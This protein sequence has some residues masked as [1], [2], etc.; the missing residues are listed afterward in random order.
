MDGR[1]GRP[2]TGR[3]DRQGGGKRGGLCVL[4]SLSLLRWSG[5]VRRHVPL[6]ALEVKSRL[7]IKVKVKVELT[8]YWTNTD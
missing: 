7:K 6:G 2:K 4:Y 1:I 3:S 8:L 5:L